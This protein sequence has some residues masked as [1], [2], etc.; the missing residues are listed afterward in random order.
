M[1][2]QTEIID[3]A[4]S[5]F[6]EWISHGWGG[7]A[8]F[9]KK[10]RKIS[11][12]AKYRYRVPNLG[13]IETVTH[14][15]NLGVQKTNEHLCASGDNRWHYNL[16]WTVNGSVMHHAPLLV[17][18][19]KSPCFFQKAKSGCSFTEPKNFQVTCRFFWKFAGEHGWFS[20]E[21]L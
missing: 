13:P 8:K 16:V 4:T 17:C 5:F 12:V 7:G 6:S 2:L 11:F 9:R 19:D 15:W 20:S 14:I 18:W 21:L 1:L 3:T 10:T